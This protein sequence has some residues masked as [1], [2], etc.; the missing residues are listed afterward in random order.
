VE[1]A[2]GGTL[3]RLFAKIA[4]YQN[5]CSF[6]RFFMQEWPRCAI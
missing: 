3:V 1:C 2:S 5:S 4:P 6:G